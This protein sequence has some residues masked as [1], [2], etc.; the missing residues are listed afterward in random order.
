M[1]FLAAAFFCISLLIG[2]VSVKVI[3]KHNFRAGIVGVD[4]NKGDQKKLPE[5]VGIALLLPI[6]ICAIAF[7]A[8]SYDFNGVYWAS[9]LTGFSIVGFADDNKPKFLSQTRKWRYRALIIAAISL[10]FSA[11]FFQEPVKLMLA[12]LFLAGVASFENTFAGLNGWEVGSGFIISVFFGLLLLGFPNFPLA[13]AMSGSILALLAF[14]VFPARV[15]PGDSGT[16]LIGSGLAGLMIW[17]QSIW[18]MVISFLF[19]IPHFIDFLAKLLT[20]PSD[21]SQRKSKPYELL[22]DSRL[23]FP[24]ATKRKY[25]FAKILI[26]IF[27]P[28]SE[29]RIVFLIWLIVL[30]NC[31]IVYVLLA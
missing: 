24:K 5:S 16:L 30:A 14:N 20:N 19:F 21:P 11:L 29:K 27:G 6:W 15:F 17:T 18:L 22:K 9:M 7:W 28:M 31:S 12:T 10:G 2:L 1:L 8:V 25:D 13:M 23:G 3:S 26:R 4:I